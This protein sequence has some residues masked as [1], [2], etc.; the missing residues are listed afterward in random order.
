M[1]G[2]LKLAFP[3]VALA[4]FAA[5][6]QRQLT[7]KGKDGSFVI[8]NYQSFSVEQDPNKPNAFSFI[9]KGSPLLAT[10]ERQ[11]LDITAKQING[12]A[13]R[14]SGQELLLETATLQGDVEV[15]ATRPSKAS[16]NQEQTVKVETATATYAQDLEKLTFS[17][18]MTL[19][20]N[21]APAGQSFRITGAKGELVLYPPGQSPQAK[22]AVRSMRL[23]GPINFDLKSRREVTSGTPP[24]R[25]M[26]PFTVKG[27]CRDLTYDDATRVLTLIQDVDIDGNDPLFLFTA[28]ASRVVITLDDM[29][30]PIKVEGE[31][32]PGVTTASD[33]PKPP[34][35]QGR[36]RAA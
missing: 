36:R 3:F 10:I 20:Q 30:N 2:R 7:L 8:R 11:K 5:A 16:A 29:G 6:G 26:Q 15:V 21:D 9:M 19:T 35:A 34:P 12:R 25:S 32:S 17:G 28:N 23:D 1:D 31:G 14:A 4:V 33:K 22:R 27:K 18:G 24:K 13:E